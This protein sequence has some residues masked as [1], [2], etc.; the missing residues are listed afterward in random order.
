MNINQ[1]QEVGSNSGTS[2]RPGM[3]EAFRSLY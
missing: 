1:E 3:E 2:Q